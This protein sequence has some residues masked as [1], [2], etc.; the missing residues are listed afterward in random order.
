MLLHVCELLIAGPEGPQ[1]PPGP[2]GLPGRDGAD[3]FPGFPGQTL[4]LILCIK[5]ALH[6][7]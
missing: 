2:P 4:P 7:F 5:D 6:L 1:G 3:G